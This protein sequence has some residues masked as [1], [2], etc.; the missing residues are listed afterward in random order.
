MLGRVREAVQ[1]AV[2]LRCI[3]LVAAFVKR[4]CD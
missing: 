2:Y 3:L 1:Y 4:I